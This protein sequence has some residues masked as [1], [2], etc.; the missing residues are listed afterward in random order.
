MSALA[1]GFFWALAV[2]FVI[3]GGIVLL[4]V[5]ADFVIR[6]FFDDL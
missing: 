4:C 2:V 6:D 1:A 5:L 3:G